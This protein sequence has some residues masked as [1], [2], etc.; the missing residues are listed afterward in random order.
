MNAAKT[1]VLHIYYTINFVA[2]CNNFLEFED[3]VYI[4]HE[5][6]VL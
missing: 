1:L 2:I 4:Y 6:S 5:Q 3:W